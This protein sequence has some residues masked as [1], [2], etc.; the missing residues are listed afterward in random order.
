MKLCL[1]FNPCLWYYTNN[2]SIIEWNTQKWA[3]KSL[4][5]TIWL[6]GFT[7]L[8]TRKYPSFT[9]AYC[10]FDC[11]KALIQITSVWIIVYKVLIF[12]F[13]IL[14]HNFICSI[15]ICYPLVTLNIMVLEICLSPLHY[16]NEH[17]TLFLSSYCLKL[18]FRS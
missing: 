14:N 2:L 11:F 7:E 18:I 17:E 5:N 4:T 12:Y 9:L 10:R 15:T 13:V 1:Y 16:F 3:E 6:Q 8:H